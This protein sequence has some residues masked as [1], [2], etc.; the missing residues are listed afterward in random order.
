VVYNA[1]SDL[2]AQTAVSLGVDPD[3]ICFD[4]GDPPHP[5]PPGRRQP[6]L[7]QMRTASKPRRGGPGVAG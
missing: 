2:A 4:R 6:R 3:Q 7:L 1:L 5:T